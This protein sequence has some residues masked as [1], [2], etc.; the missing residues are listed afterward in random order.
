MHSYGYTGVSNWILH[1]QLRLFKGHQQGGRK[2]D[3]YTDGA[4]DTSIR[5]SCHASWYR[6]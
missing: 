6:C 3:K 4:T 5:P 1:K 2:E